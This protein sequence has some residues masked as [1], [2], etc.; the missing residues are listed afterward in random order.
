MEKTL[1][2]LPYLESGNNGISLDIHVLQ[3]DN[4]QGNSQPF[5]FQLAGIEKPFTRLIKGGLKCD[6]SKRIFHPVFMLVQ[7]DT[8]F[9]DR[10]DFNPQTNTT[11]D[12]AWLDTIHFFSKDRDTFIIP[13]PPAIHRLS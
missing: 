9:S 1:S 11:L 6:G 13:S 7:K 4:P 3:P 12:Q 10:G 2:L 5:P 8:G